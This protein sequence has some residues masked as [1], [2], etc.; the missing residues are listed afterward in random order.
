MEQLEEGVL[1]W[2]RKKLTSVKDVL[3]K[4]QIRSG[5]FYLLN[6]SSKGY[7]QGTLDYYDMVPIIL[8]LKEDSKYVLGLNT[9]YLP[10]KN[11]EQLIKLL[12]KR[13]SKQ[14]ENNDILPNIQW[15]NI[16]YET[17]VRPEFIIKLYRKDRISKIVKIQTKDIET[18]LRIDL[19]AF[20][21]VDVKK[22]WKYFKAG[23]PP[24]K[25]PVKNIDTYKQKRI[26]D[27]LKQ[28]K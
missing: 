24:N 23:I 14:F 4:N 20:V 10:I 13:Y 27:I 21:G 15:N 17:Q 5:G 6:Y 25:I 9:N 11:K 26:I 1:D 12:K 3:S 19:S 8:V 2:L 28:Y 22:V 16:K 7:E 18:T